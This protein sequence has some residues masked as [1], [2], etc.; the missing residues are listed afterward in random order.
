MLVL[1][2]AAVSVLI[3]VVRSA[4]A[5]DVSGEQ[6]V[7]ATGAAE[8][9]P[10]YVHVFGAVQRL[11]QRDGIGERDG[12]RDRHVHV[13]AAV[14]QR[15]PGRLVEETAGIDQRRAGD[16]GGNPVEKIARRGFR[17]RPDRDPPPGRSKRAG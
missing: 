7:A 3:G 15:V 9:P 4:G 10:V 12:K 5:P 11:P 6:V 14:A 17:A 1:V 13:G 16:E 2:I 8:L